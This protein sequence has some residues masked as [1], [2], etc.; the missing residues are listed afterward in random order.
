[1]NP[2][3]PDSIAPKVNHDTE[4]NNA[5]EHLDSSPSAVFLLRVGL[6]GEGAEEI[7]KGDS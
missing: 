4:G 6:E 7:E 3:Q 5:L 2:G 1:M